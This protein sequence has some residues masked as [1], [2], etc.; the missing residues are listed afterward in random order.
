MRGIDLIQIVNPP[1]GTPS[2]YLTDGALYLDVNENFISLKESL[3]EISDFSKIKGSGVLDTDIPMSPK[4]YWIFRK[5]ISPLSKENLDEGYD[6]RVFAGGILQLPQTK[7]LFR[8]SE[9]KKDEGGFI[10][11]RIESDVDYWRESIKDLYIN[12]LDF[13]SFTVNETNLTNAWALHLWDQNEE[14]YVWFPLVD[15]GRFWNDQ[16]SFVGVMVEDFLP[17]FSVEGIL[18]KGFNEL[19]YNW[20]TPLNDSEWYKSLWVMILGEIDYDG[21]GQFFEVDMRYSSDVNYFNSTALF[22]DNVVLDQSESI[23]EE[24]IVGTQR[25]RH[26]NFTEV[27]SDYKLVLTG[28]IENNLNEDLY[29]DVEVFEGQTVEVIGT[30]PNNLVGANSIVEVEIEVDYNLNHGNSV[31]VMFNNLSAGSGSDYVI[32]GGFKASIKGTSNRLYKNDVVQWNQLI[33]PDLTFEDFLE[34]F[35][36]L[37]DG[38]FFEDEENRSVMMF[39]KGD[40]ELSVFGSGVETFLRPATELIN[41]TNVVGDYS[42]KVKVEDKK[43]KRFYRLKFKGNGDPY[44]REVLNLRDTEDLWGKLVDRVEGDRG[45]VKLE[46][47]LFE[48]MGNINYKGLSLPAVWDNTSRVRTKRFG[49][50]IMSAVGLVEQKVNGSNL[51]QSVT[52]GFEF[53]QRQ[54]LPYGSQYPDREYLEDGSYV[55]PSMNVVYE[56]DLLAEDNLFNVFYDEYFRDLESGVSYEYIVFMDSILWRNLSF[57]KKVGVFYRGEWAV[58]KL[59]LKNDYQVGSQLPVLLE[60]IPMYDIIPI[61]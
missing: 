4:N 34:A 17:W 6:V 54:S 33:D 58:Y 26:Y 59:I 11:I 40:E 12:D 2:K 30:A 1:L 25:T 49:K 9:D 20:E 36:D 19:G 32:K 51:D 23:I 41:L 16:Q 13:G 48:P 15:Y 24:N 44:I 22:F 10:T 42:R 29:F 47:K 37:V 46:N 50:R 53:N 55:R 61:K 52:W 39:P 45:E 43:R 5:F 7:L 3:G 18:K 31:Y 60:M 57:R 8:G 14:N 35:V 56:G 27:V 38:V 28:S 21:K